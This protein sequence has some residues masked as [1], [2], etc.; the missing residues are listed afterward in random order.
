MKKFDIYCARNV[1]ELK[2]V[3]SSGPRLVQKKKLSEIK[4]KTICI[5][6]NFNKFFL[7]GDGKWGLAGWW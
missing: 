1:E 2:A 3:I 6:K 7:D 5:T 4:Q